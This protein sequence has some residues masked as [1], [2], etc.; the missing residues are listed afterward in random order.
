MLRVGSEGLYEWLVTDEEFDLLHVCPEIVLGK[1]VAITS[2]DSS[3]LVPSEKETASGGRV[4]RKL[5]TAPK[6]RVLRKYQPRALM[7]GT[8]LTS[9]STSV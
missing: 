1:Y 4:A 2:I 7:N 8:S 6:F 5:R 3:S 9:Q